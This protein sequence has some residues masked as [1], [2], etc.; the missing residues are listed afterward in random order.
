M[1]ERPV[2][3]VFLYAR[4]EPIILVAWVPP[5]V[6]ASSQI[7]GYSD[8]NG[9]PYVGLRTPTRPLL[10]VVAIGVVSVP[11]LYG[12]CYMGYLCCMCCMYQIS[13]VYRLC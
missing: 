3:P 6:G 12:L 11:H 5:V 7:T 4:F 2:M 13:S 10:D 8:Y 9:W 1:L